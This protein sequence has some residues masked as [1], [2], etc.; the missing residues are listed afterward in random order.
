MRTW[1]A[2]MALLVGAA[3]GG[4]GGTDGASSS[5]GEDAGDGGGVALPGLDARPVNATCRAPARP[6]T[7]TGGVIGLTPA[8]PNMDFDGKAIGVVRSRRGASGP[9]RWFV[10]ERDG[11]IWTFVDDKASKDGLAADGVTAVPRAELFFTLPVTPSGLQGEGGLLGVAFDPDF[12]LRDDAGFVYLHYTTFPENNVWR[13]RIGGAPGGF[14]IA[15]SERIFTTPSGGT[16]HWGGDLKFG[17]DGYLYVALGDGGNGY[18]EADAQKLSWMR[19]KILRIDPRSVATGYAVPPNNPFGGASRCDNLDL[20][21]L[22]ARTDACPE[23]FAYGFRNPWRITFDRETGDLWLGDV[24]TRKEEIDLVRS[25][26]NYG[27][28][29][30]DG[31]I[32]TGCPP[33]NAA[34]TMI[35]PVAQYREFSMGAASVTGGY[36]YRGSALGTALRGAYIFS[37]FYSGQLFVID[38]PYANVAE[39]FAVTKTYEHPLAADYPNAPKFRVLDG[40]T[41]PMVVTFAEDENAEL[42]A[43]TFGAGKGQGVLRLSPPGA[44]VAD[45]IPSLL[46]KTGCVDPNDPTKPAPGVIP[47]E[48]N[49][50][51]WSDGADKTRFFALPDGKTIGIGPGGDWDLPNESVTM[52]HFRLGGKLIETRLFVRH[53]DGGWAGYTY[54]WNDA[55]TDAVKANPVGETRAVGA[56]TWSYPSRARCTSCHTREAGGTL[57]L[58]T[59]QLNRNVVYAAT[60]RDANQIDTL[61]H[62][63]MFAAA[64]GKAATLPAFVAPFGDGPLETRAR[65]YLHANC[66]SCHRGDRRPALEIDKTLAETG[67]CDDPALIVPGDPAA[68]RLVTLLE[69]PDLTVRMPKNAGNVIDAAGVKLVSDWIRSRKSCP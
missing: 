4:D 7:S 68:S 43:V 31:V 50:P 47:Y 38:Q 22:T 34:S 17:P 19:G 46:S 5:G 26:K 23:V 48:L 55:Q 14:T 33:A 1:L 56:E 10:V 40:A 69:S 32:G 37:D 20:A 61:A 30:C 6:P 36:V 67:L 13:F 41:V 49:A 11:K 53:L 45:T 21:T 58:E 35:A 8:F 51:F 3:C 2:G 9:L 63:G 57:G 12:G 27:W 59:R 42:L 18:R 54:V 65:V 66:S 29:V 52:K 16:N 25:G 60:G 28:S 39:P 44:P 62:I 24:G 15:S 64:P